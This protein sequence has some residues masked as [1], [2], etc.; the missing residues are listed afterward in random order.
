MSPIRTS[1]G[2][3]L[4]DREIYELKPR[5]RTGNHVLDI[6]LAGK[7]MRMKNA[8]IQFTCVADGETLKNMQ[9]A[10]ICAIFGNAL[11]NAIEYAEQIKDPQKRVI[12]MTLSRRRDFIFLEISNYCESSIRVENGLPV[13]TK[14]NRELHGY[15]VRSMVQAAR[16]YGGTVTFEE[17][18]H[19][20]IVRFLIPETG[21]K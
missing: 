17:K 8:L 15:G 13:T 3:I 2:N 9:V 1:E 16:K 11:D 7:E 4:T 10:D 6:I 18:D 5:I 20:F 19:F 14:E 21:N 12:S